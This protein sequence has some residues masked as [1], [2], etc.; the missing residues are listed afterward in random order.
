MLEW[1]QWEPLLWTAVT[2]A[3][4]FV[5]GYLLHVVLWAIVAAVS[6]R[7]GTGV[8]DSVIRHCRRP[9]VLILPCLAGYLSL[10]F[11]ERWAGAPA[12]GFLGDL[13]VMLLIVS[14][15]WT[16]IRLTSVAQDIVTSR[17]D[18]DAADNLR[19]RAVLTQFGILRKIVA[20]V[21]VILA[22]GMILMSFERFRQVGTGILASAGLAGLVLGLAAQRTL[23]NLLAGVQLAITQPI[24]IDDVVIVE[25]EWG[26]IEEITLTYVVVRIWDL[27]RLVLPISYFLEKPFQNWTRVSAD[28]LGTVF[29]YMD[30]TVP[31]E[32]VR[33]ELQRIVEGSDRWDGKVSG[34]QVT[35]ATADSVEVRALISAEDASKAWE[36]RCEVRE[37]LIAFLQRE[38]PGS[39]PRIR[40]EIRDRQGAEISG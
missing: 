1:P 7:T 32:A 33:G 24:R 34:V 20:V 3:G 40:A 26:R 25:G 21:V 9:T 28:L 2:V 15:A 38:Y 31:V 5:A 12:R 16:V 35:G 39:L 11:V 36:L 8:D 29:L 19:A 30:Y 37:K 17:F 27:R 13:L 14:V 18:V 10:P 23:A 22:L 4:A 6:R